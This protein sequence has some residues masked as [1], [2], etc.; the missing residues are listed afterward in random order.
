MKPV[1]ARYTDPLIWIK[2]SG[3]QTELQKHAEII[4][5]QRKGSKMVSFNITEG[6]PGALTFLMAA[7]DASPFEAEYCF[8]RMQDAG[9]TGS[10]LYMLW[11]DCCNRNTEFAMEIM[12]NRDIEN[13]CRHIDGGKGCG[14]KFEEL[15]INAA[16]KTSNTLGG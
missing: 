1:I 12:K 15:L 14:I 11:N 5:K 4:K 3:T 16:D 8:Q 13:I 7:Y 10:R 2:R 9:I 6:N